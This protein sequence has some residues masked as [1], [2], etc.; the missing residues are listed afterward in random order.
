MIQFNHV[1]LLA[2]FP[3]STC[4]NLNTCETYVHTVKI[5]ENKHEA[6]K[7]KKKEIPSNAINFKNPAVTG[8]KLQH[9]EQ[10]NYLSQCL[11]G[12]MG[13]PPPHIEPARKNFPTSWHTPSR[14]APRPS[15]SSTHRHKLSSHTQRTFPH[16]PHNHPWAYHNPH[17]SSP[18]EPAKT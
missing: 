18:Q 14:S 15:Q 10:R 5:T 13:R 9:S 8:G 4:A 12:T 16:R 11:S 6:I 3:P 7:R 17:N 1:F 2:V